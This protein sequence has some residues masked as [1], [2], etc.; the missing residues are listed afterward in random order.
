M[1]NK[2][3]ILCTSLLLSS[4]LSFASTTKTELSDSDKENQTTQKKAQPFKK[5]DLQNLFK[6]RLEQGVHTQTTSGNHL[7]FLFTASEGKSTISSR[8]KFHKQSLEIL[9]EEGFFEKFHRLWD[10]QK[11][12]SE[13]ELCKELGMEDLSDLQE[14]VKGHRHHILMHKKTGLL[15][16]LK[17]IEKQFS[18]SFYLEEHHRKLMKGDDATLRKLFSSLKYKAEA[19]KLYLYKKSQNN[20]LAIPV[21]RDP[22]ETV[23]LEKLIG[24]KNFDRIPASEVGELSRYFKEDL[25][26]TLGH[27]AYHA[28]P[29]YMTIKSS[30]H[31]NNAKGL[32]Y[33]EAFP[34]LGQQKAETKVAPKSSSDSVATS[35]MSMRDA[36]DFS[37]EYIP[38]FSISSQEHSSD[39]FD[40][41]DEYI[42]TSSSISS[43]ESS[44]SNN[45]NT[46]AEYDYSAMPA[47][48]YSMMYAYVY[49]V[50]V[51]VAPGPHGNPIMQQT[52]PYSPSFTH[53]SMAY[54]PDFHG[55]N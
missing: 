29:I 49:P 53:V 31:I 32:T 38:T 6:E 7:S 50:P 40:F 19:F 1:T 43:E 35:S 36:F 23:S 28:L 20:V 41:S 45:E 4:S 5:S 27:M 34:S 52:T 44:S 11:L 42:P 8:Y 10:A 25:I 15:L 47:Y 12:S 55:Q 17:P 26:G 2:L 3:L 30:T 39:E 21:P 51:L 46:D 18:F 16:R 9:K 22:I 33:E 48:D 54:N 14:V 13:K 37:E 24:S